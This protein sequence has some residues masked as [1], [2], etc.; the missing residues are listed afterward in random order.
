MKYDPTINLGEMIAAAVLLTGLVT[1]HIQNVR[2][3]NTIETKVNI[4]FNWFSKNIIN[5]G[6]GGGEDN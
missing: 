5:G 1:A 6:G 3:L 4:M 2:R